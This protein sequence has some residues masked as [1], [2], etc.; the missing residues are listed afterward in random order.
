MQEA[1]DVHAW[2]MRRSRLRQCLGSCEVLMATELQDTKTLFFCNNTA[3]SKPWC[4]RDP[5]PCYL[6]VKTEGRMEGIVSKLSFLASA[7][8]MRELRNVRSNVSICFFKRIIRI[9]Y[10]SS[11]SLSKAECTIVRV[12]TQ[13]KKNRGIEIEGEE[14]KRENK[15]REER[16]NTWKK[17]KKVRKRRR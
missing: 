6:D 14:E 9:F 15:E 11:L 5:Q 4:S 7:C 10:I 1:C 2:R 16:G 12:R 3:L 17:R 13:K 8:V